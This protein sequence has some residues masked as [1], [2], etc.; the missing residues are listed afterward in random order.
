MSISELL[1]PET[2]DTIVAE[3]ITDEEIIATVHK[4]REEREM[5]EING[6]DDGAGP[7]GEL[8]LPAMPTRKEVLHASS[9]LQ[10]YIIGMN[11]PLAHKLEAILVSFG[12]QICLEDTQAT[13]ATQITDY[14]TSFA[15]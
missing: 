8:E 11:N 6:G 15:A 1:N 9:T 5:M 2:E 4:R 3:G 13:R 12:H 7:L 14:F 10:E